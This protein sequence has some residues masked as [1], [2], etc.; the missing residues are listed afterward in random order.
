M[1][2]NAISVASVFFAVVAGICL[3]ATNQCETAWARRSLWLLSAAMIQLRLVA[4]LMDGMVAIEGGKK[5]AVGDLYNEV[6]D[7]LSDPAILVG[8]GF[9]W[10]SSPTIGLSAALVAVF[11]AYV[12]AIGASVGVGQVFIGPFAKQQRMALMTLVCIISAILPLPWQAVSESAGIGVC[13]AALLLLIFGGLITACRRLQKIAELMR[14]RE[15][16]GT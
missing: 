16:A 1:T 4:N 9:A 11:V 6:P 10:G 15:K 5:S 14:E 12:R 7:R 2:P 3:A 8:A 13:G